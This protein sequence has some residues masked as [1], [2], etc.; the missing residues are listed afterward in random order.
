[1]LD[2]GAISLD[3]KRENILTVSPNISTSRLKRL[4]THYLITHRE[5]TDATT[6]HT[7]YRHY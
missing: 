6:H 5:S 3:E 1:M 7:R 4:P 2:M